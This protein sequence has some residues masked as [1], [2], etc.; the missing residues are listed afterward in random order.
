MSTLVDDVEYCKLADCDSSQSFVEVDPYAVPYENPH[1][2]EARQD[3]A[4]QEEVMTKKQKEA[5]K[6]EVIAKQAE[7][8]RILELE[9]ANAREREF[10]INATQ[11]EKDARQ[12]QLRKR[13]EAAYR[14]ANRIVAPVD[15]YDKYQEQYKKSKKPMGT[16]IGSRKK[17]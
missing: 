13:E 10:K 4:R 11:A 9:E 15:I 14:L 5:R 6:A 17:R 8:A 3:A 7:D 12:E 2:E 1:E 16:K